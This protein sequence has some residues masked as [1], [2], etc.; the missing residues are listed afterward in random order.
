M[1][2]KSNPPRI[3]DDM[4]WFDMEQEER[5]AMTM[6]SYQKILLDAGNAHVIQ[7]NSTESLMTVIIHPSTHKGEA[8]LW[9]ISW[10]DEAGIPSMHE[11]ASSREAALM[12]MAGFDVEGGHLRGQI[13]HLW[14]VSGKR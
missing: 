8:G 3:P 5:D 1:K 7:L 14:F 6:E 2:R 12:Y 13:P 4:E 9:Q 11:T 10:L